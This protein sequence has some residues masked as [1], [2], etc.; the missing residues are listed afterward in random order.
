MISLCITTYNRYEMLM[1]SFAQVLND[2]RISEIVIVDD[3]SDIAI[4]DK[5]LAATFDMA[6]VRLIRNTEN[7]GMSLNK[8]KA[9]EAAKNEWCIIF[10]SDNIM[11]PDY[12]DALDKIGTLDP[13]TIYCP[14]FAQPNFDYR[15]FEGWHILR[16]EAIKLLG[17][18]MGECL[19]NT[20]NYVLH[21]EKYLQVY[22]HNPNIDA[23]DTIHFNHLWL[24]ADYSFYVVPNM[25]YTH[26]VH[27]GSGFL[28]NVNKNMY[29]AKEIK[30]KI[31]SL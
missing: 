20:A 7:L 22:R 11:S 25:H 17:D 18:R 19:F 27:D 1:E 2:D 26:R 24:K 14:S 6:K 29:D 4:Y 31:L 3:C 13:H 10:D 9:I 12:L 28:K 15:A 30:H 5:I 21:R 23:A 16:P 8:K